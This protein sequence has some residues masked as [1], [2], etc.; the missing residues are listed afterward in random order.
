MVLGDMLELGSGAP[1]LHADLALSLKAAQIDIVFTAGPLMEHLHQ[2]L[3]QTMRGRHAK[4]SKT[5]IPIV[6]AALRA[7]DVVAIKGS[8]SSHM[9]LVVAA[10]LALKATPTT[11]GH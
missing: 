11:H 1:A 10:L 2:A 6:I 9:E 3:P 5:L 8:H 7:G 4:D